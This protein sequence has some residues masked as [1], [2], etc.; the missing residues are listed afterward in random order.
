M[1]TRA[2]LIA[3]NARPQNRMRRINEACR[4]QPPSS[5]P[6]NAISAEVAVAI[7]RYARRARPSADSQE[8]DVREGGCLGLEQVRSLG[9]SARETSAQLDLAAFEH[10]RVVRILNTHVVRR[11]DPCL[12]IHELR[13]CLPTRRLSPE[14]AG[15]FACRPSSEETR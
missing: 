7:K 8:V 10:L 3:T 1:N 11:T 4:V 9:G 12:A 14:D 5:R 13:E 2:C 6:R 15:R